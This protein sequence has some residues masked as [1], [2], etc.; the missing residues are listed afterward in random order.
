MDAVSD[1]A[2][3]NWRRERITYNGTFC[4][5]FV[6]SRSRVVPSFCHANPTSPSPTPYNCSRSVLLLASFPIC[7]SIA[8]R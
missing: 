6:V 7:S 4:R 5:S 3:E 2:L 8:Q 1:H